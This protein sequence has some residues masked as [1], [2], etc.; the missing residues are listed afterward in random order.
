MTTHHDHSEV[1]DRTREWEELYAGAE[2][3]WSGNPNAALVDAVA[4]LPGGRA[5]DLGCGEG[6]DAIWL[7]QHGWHVDA[8]D[9]SRTAID[10]ARAAATAAGAAGV[11]FHVG[12]VVDWSQSKENWSQGKENGYD[13]VCASFLHSPDEQGRHR[14][15]EQAALLVAPGGRLLII[16][17]A[18]PA[19]WVDQHD[20]SGHHHHLSASP[21]TDRALT[22]VDDAW[23]AEI[24]Q[25]R[26]RTVTAPD[27]AD[28]VLQDSVLLLRRPA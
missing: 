17:H 2:P 8:V 4:Q 3:R 9:L 5:V 23:V 24:A 13:L 18:A 10:R 26:D 7:A 25:V 19:P 21:E 1:N 27:G 11:T 15:L 22:G 6:A 12:D 28:A 16:S 14:L 20:G